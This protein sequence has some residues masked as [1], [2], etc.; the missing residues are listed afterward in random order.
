MAVALDEP[1]MIRNRLQRRRV[2]FPG[3]SF[4]ARG[5][6]RPWFDPTA[7][8]SSPRGFSRSQ[9]VERSLAEASPSTPT[10][11]RREPA[12]IFALCG[13]ELLLTAFSLV[14]AAILIIPF[15][16]DLCCG[17]PFWR[18]SVL[19]DVST[20]ICGLG[21]VLLSWNVVRDLR[22]KMRRD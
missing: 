9:P 20:V 19:F 5:T 7:Q 4:Q 16:V 6:N 18:A 13:V 1:R 15:A 22:R 12:G 21:L 14:V 8:R 17:W 11:L 3:D 2:T 10:S